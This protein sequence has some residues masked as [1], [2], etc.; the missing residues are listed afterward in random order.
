MKVIGPAPSVPDS[1]RHPVSLSIGQIKVVGPTPDVR[2]YE[3]KITFAANHSNL[4]DTTPVIVPPPPSFAGLGGSKHQMSSA[5]GTGTQVVPPPPVVQI[6]ASYA[7]GSGD[8]RPA[9]VVP[10]PPSIN[11]I[12][13]SGGQYGKSLSVANAQV[14]P[15]APQLN[16]VG[17][18]ARG[19]IGGVAG[20]V[21][22]PPP[23]MA[24]FGRSGSGQALNSLRGSGMQVQPPRAVIQSA[25]TGT[26][27]SP[28]TLAS[29]RPGG[30]LPGE[31]V[32][33][34]VGSTTND[35][36]L[37]DPKFPETKELSVDF[38]GPA[39][40]LPASSYFLSYEV[41]IA[42]ERVARHQ[43]RLIKL[44]YDFLPYQRRLS[45][46]GPNYP[47]IENLRA[48]RDPSCDETFTQ[49][50]SSANAVGWPKADRIQLSTKS[51][52]QRQT[53]LPCYRTTADDYRR[54]RARQQR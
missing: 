9:L 18:Q 1:I 48:T 14:V 40:V 23:S 42:E 37:A 12:H 45:E 21:V 20:R 8:G 11:G 52:R 27:S 15:P 41:F 38:I 43:S 7:T 47:S 36:E 26:N 29:A 49:V 28:L 24:G 25:S 22:P 39:L 30:L 46:Y 13:G 44:V 10:P 33:D 51:I 16:G 34:S 19:V 54:A 35:K 31:I 6:A 4:G 53:S 32:S 5:A 2:L 3:S 17:T 50:E